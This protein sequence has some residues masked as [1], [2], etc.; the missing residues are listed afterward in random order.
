VGG[1][2]RAGEAVDER[3]RGLVVAR[4]TREGY[5]RAA[6]DRAV[7]TGGWTDDRT[8]AAF[9]AGEGGPVPTLGSRLR[10][11]LDP[12]SERERRIRRTVAA[13]DDFADAEASGRREA[14]ANGVDGGAGS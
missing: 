10:L 5:D 12:E 11:W 7:A 2:E 4:L 14:S 8:A 6:A 13:L 3:L 1:D 9:L